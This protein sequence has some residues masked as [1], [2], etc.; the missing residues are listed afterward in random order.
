MTEVVR[1]LFERQVERCRKE[2]GLVGLRLRV[3]GKG[4]RM[5]ISVLEEEAVRRSEALD[6]MRAQLKLLQQRQRQGGG[7]MRDDV[8]GGE[9]HAEAQ[10]SN[11]SKHGMMTNDD[12]HHHPHREDGKALL[13]PSD[14]MNAMIDL[15]HDLASIDQEID[16]FFT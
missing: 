5:R 15:P 6:A 10:P 14:N 3:E 1:V 11:E 4:L 13:E 16:S 7:D 9:L 12:N 8:L 2:A